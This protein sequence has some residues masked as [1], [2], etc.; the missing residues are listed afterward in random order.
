M[1]PLGGGIGIALGRVVS[2]RGEVAALPDRSGRQFL[3]LVAVAEGI[4]DAPFRANRSLWPWGDPLCEN[5]WALLD[6]GRRS[7]RQGRGRIRN[8]RDEAPHLKWGNSGHSELTLGAVFANLI[9]HEMNDLLATLRE[10][11]LAAAPGMHRQSGSH[12]E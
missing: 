2:Y 6:R 4:A 1:Y 5:T 11:W 7:L 9:G 12:G 3:A 10:A 8:D